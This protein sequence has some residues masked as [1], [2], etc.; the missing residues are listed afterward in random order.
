MNHTAYTP[1]L[2]G[3]STTDGLDTVINWGLGADSTAYLA[4]MLTAPAAY[5]IDL[6]RTAVL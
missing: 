6:D 4:R 3:L 5:G 1:S 2:P